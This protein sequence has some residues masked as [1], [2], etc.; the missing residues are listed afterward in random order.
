MRG[1]INDAGLVSDL[2]VRHEIEAIVNFAAESHVDRSIESPEP[3]LQT[4]VLG[5]FRLLETA[6]RHHA[7]L[8]GNRAAAFR[9][10]HVSTDEVFGSLGPGDA[11]FTEEHPHRPNSP[12]AA[13]K[14]AA[15]HLVRAYFHTFGAPVVTTN[16]SNNYGPRQFPEK[17]IPL[18]LLSAL[19]GKSIPI[20]GDGRQVRDWLYVDDHC[21]AIWQ[22]LLK[23]RLGGTYNIGGGNERSN[24]DLVGALCRVLDA[25][26]PRTD[27]KPYHEQITHVPDRPGHD[28]RYA[29]DH[30]RISRELGWHP[31]ESLA[32]GLEK[33]VRW[34]LAHRAW[35]E[36]VARSG[37]YQGERLGAGRVEPVTAHA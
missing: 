21:E 37:S 5:T 36:T 22:V 33:T 27:G 32:S 3:F 11:A 26:S 14:A 35:C 16:C 6:A 2:L 7:T 23:G 1:D 19:S 13:S 15:D 9:L 25:I 4:N 31:R 8:P 17:L 34:Y 20:Y 12:Y 28:R 29:I 24:L 30:G 18:A 10:L